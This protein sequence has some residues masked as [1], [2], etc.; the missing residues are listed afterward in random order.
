MEISRFLFLEKKEIQKEET[1]I[2][3]VQ[4]FL[5]DDNNWN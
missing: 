2:K 4:A 1:E 5:G 3:G